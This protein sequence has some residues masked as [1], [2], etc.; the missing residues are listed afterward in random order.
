MVCAYD[1]S[2]GVR[3]DESDECDDSCEC[4]CDGGKD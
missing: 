2:H 3:D 1:E 4:D